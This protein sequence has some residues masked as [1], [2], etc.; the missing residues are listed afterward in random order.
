MTKIKRWASSSPGRSRIVAHKNLIWV[1]STVSNVPEFEKEIKECL[2]L[3]EKSLLDAGSDKEHILSIQV[4]LRNIEYK[5]LFDSIWLQ[6]IGLD[7]NNWPQRSVIGAI[8]TPGLEIEI[9]ATAL[10]YN[11]PEIL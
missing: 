8:L 11:K 4:I 1:V 3:L 5:N 2:K 10:K 9:V 7:P 6:W